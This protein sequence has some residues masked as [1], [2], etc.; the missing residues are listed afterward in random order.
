MIIKE[1]KFVE[2]AMLMERSK[3]I[4]TL[5]KGIRKRERKRK[6]ITS[7]QETKNNPI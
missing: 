1:K 4:K 7:F 2:L 3:K 6:N 5:M